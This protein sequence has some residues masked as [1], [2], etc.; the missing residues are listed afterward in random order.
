MDYYPFAQV[1]NYLRLVENFPGISRVLGM[2]FEHM[3]RAGFS[4]D[5]GYLFGFSYGAQLV[6]R[7][8][9]R[10]GHQ[11]FKDIVACDPAGPGFDLIRATVDFKD[12]AQNVECIHTSINLGTVH[13]TLCHQNWRMG[14]CGMQQE[15]AGSLEFRSHGLCPLFYNSA[16]K[17]DFLAIEKPQQCKATHSATYW[18]EKFKLGY[19][20]RR[21]S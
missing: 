10:H 6:L 9:R 14:D 12:A 11:A 5:Q 1:R 20:E 4:F 2:K 7:A 18:P 8:A 15:A 19:T 13:T 16:F 3:V 21:K 17:H